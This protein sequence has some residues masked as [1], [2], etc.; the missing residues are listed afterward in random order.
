MA[1]AVFVRAAFTLVM[2]S[3][4]LCLA[5]STPAEVWSQRYSGPPSSGQ[6][7]AERIARDAKGD[8]VVF[9]T[10]LDPNGTSDFVTIKY[11]GADGSMLWSRR[12]EV[13]K[14][15][16]ERI[17]GLALDAA[18][19]VFITGS[20][21]KTG[22][23]WQLYS[24]KYSG[25]DG[26]VLWK[27]THA[28][29]DPGTLEE[30][31]VSVAVD[32][33]GDATIAAYS[34]QSGRADLY[35]ARYASTNGAL[36]WDRV[37]TNSIPRQGLAPIAMVLDSAGDI[38]VTGNADLDMHTAKYSG[39]NGNLIWEIRRGVG[40]HDR[41]LSLV[42]DAAGDLI[43]AG[44]SSD[45][46][47][48]Y[49]IYVA[50]YRASDGSVLW[51]K[52]YNGPENGDD[53]PS[54]LAVDQDGN[55][56]LGGSSHTNLLIAKYSGNNGTTLWEQRVP[57]RE[58]FGLQ[59]NSLAVDQNSDLTVTA[60]LENAFTAKYSGATG[61]VIWEKRSA[62]R[63]SIFSNALIL[64]PNGD[65]FV[66][67]SANNDFY[68]VRYAASDGAPL[69]EKT[70][71]EPAKGVDVPRATAIDAE[72][73]VVVFGSSNQ[74]LYTAKYEAK[75]GRLLWERRYSPIGGSFANAAAM[76][77]DGAGNVIIS[78][79]A[80][81][82]TNGF[83]NPVYLAK[84]AASNGTILWERYVA[85][86]APISTKISGL[87]LD[88]TGNVVMTGSTDDAFRGEDIYTAK[89]SATDGALLWERSY[90][91]AGRNYDQAN[92]L[93]LDP[94]GDVIITGSL[95]YGLG[96]DVYSAKYGAADG[97]IIWEQRLP[98]NARFRI[99]Q[100]DPSGNVVAIGIRNRQQHLA[101]F[102]ANT[103][104]L[105]WERMDTNGVVSRGPFLKVDS[106]GNI[107]TASLR[108]FPIDTIPFSFNVTVIQKHSSS[109]ALLWEQQ[110][111]RDSHERPSLTLMTLDSMENLL[112]VGALHNGSGIGND[113]F[114]V[115]FATVDGALLWELNKADYVASA[116]AFD[117]KGALAVTGSTDVDFV[118]LLLR[119]DL[120][121]LR[122][123]RNGNVL[124]L[125]WPAAYSN[126]R[127]ESQSEPLGLRP[128]ATWN[129][130]AVS[131]ATNSLTLPFDFNTKAAFFRI[132]RP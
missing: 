27:Q 109:G 76:I 22:G 5:Q 67:G 130:V 94:A 87:A 96:N 40:E 84:Y 49:D 110:Y 80:R 10:T 17:G 75:A 100:T 31:S 20:S 33:K 101:K 63:S 29:A 66:T 81:F 97:A 83:V 34:S 2:V 74:D 92:A 68:T 51:E 77:L 23:E 98:S 61:A 119:E 69:W 39:T 3:P 58:N 122:A 132:A 86:S 42:T 1:F 6:D 118:T 73:I 59:V 8:V 121:I 30:H 72:G 127:L 129:P 13:P 38:F 131:P 54:G 79:T 4:A 112:L 117:A 116:V 21:I 52:Q 71:N 103:G 41:G 45:F 104:A 12:A 78:G 111:W 14:D 123:T 28:D 50:K 48:L 19:D 57:G 82:A 46:S 113:T 16:E 70:H 36:L 64:A 35:L 65:A 60:T 44:Y 18:G 24:A 56:F 125:S 85:S 43:V 90:T 120:P 99:L 26:R 115:R 37:H 55:I 11:S 88:Q 53:I 9:G 124:Q 15:V 7:K 106:R 32:A 91:S 47:T 114:M 105:L 102:D 108:T 89:F 62:P 93:A 95:Q 25:A 107:F 128:N 126:W